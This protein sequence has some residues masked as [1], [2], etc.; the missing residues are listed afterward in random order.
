MNKLT[1][2][3]M[4]QAVTACMEYIDRL[5]KEYRFLDKG[6]SD[7]L[8][9]HEDSPQEDKV[10]HDWESLLDEQIRKRRMIGAD[11]ND[12]LKEIRVAKLALEEAGAAGFPTLLGAIKH[13]H[14]CVN[15]EATRAFELEGELEDVRSE[16]KKERREMACRHCWRD[17][18]R[19]A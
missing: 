9:E 2:E 7:V 12:A 3:Q 4:P 8:K 13:L 1:D 6:V 19:W 11:L 18:G 16:K 15:T 17:G 10:N 14:Q 5:Q